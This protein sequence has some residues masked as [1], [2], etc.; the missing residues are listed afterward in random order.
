MFSHILVGP[1]VHPHFGD[2]MLI[3]LFIVAIGAAF[4]WLG[5]R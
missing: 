5:R 2:L 4:M 3:A 1:H